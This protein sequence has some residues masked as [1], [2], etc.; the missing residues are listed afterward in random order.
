MENRERSN[1][2]EADK[3]AN[4]KKVR[5]LRNVKKWSASELAER[6]SVDAQHIYRIER[7][8]SNPSFQLLNKIAL[9]FGIPVEALLVHENEGVDVQSDDFLLYTSKA[10]LT[11]ND[12]SFDVIKFVGSAEKWDQKIGDA[13]L[14]QT[15]KTQCDQ[16]VLDVIKKLVGNPSEAH[17]VLGTASFKVP[18][19]LIDEFLLRIIDKVK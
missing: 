14:A 6:V 3:K 11:D 17:L 19:E 12:E 8:E 10:R 15:D 9:E 16:S 4:G 18:S 2:G 5:E 7:G 13:Q 1:N